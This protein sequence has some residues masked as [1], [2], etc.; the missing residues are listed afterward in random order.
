MVS[1]VRDKS[2]FSASILYS[3]KDIRSFVYHHARCRCFPLSMPIRLKT[4]TEQCDRITNAL[5]D[6]EFFIA[7]YWLL[8]IDHTLREIDDEKAT[9]EAIRSNTVFVVD[10]TN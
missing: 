5:N 8:L 6:N 9:A 2:L 7:S 3:S 1:Y 4:I 10:K